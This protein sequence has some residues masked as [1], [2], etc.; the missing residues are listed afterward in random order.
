[1]GRTP[2]H[3]AAMSGNTEMVNALLMVGSKVDEKDVVSMLRK[4]EGD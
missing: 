2:L 3:D 4:Y 1:M